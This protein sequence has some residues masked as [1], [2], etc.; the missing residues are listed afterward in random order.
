MVILIILII[1]L[2]LFTLF[3]QPSIQERFQDEQ[4]FRYRMGRGNDVNKRRTTL[5]YFKNKNMPEEAYLKLLRRKNPF[6][7]FAEPML[8][9]RC[10]EFIHDPS[11]RRYGI[12]QVISE[13]YAD[14]KMFVSDKITVD[15]IHYDTIE[16][17]LFTEIYKL[18]MR[19]N[20]AA[21]RID[22][23][24]G[25]SY[26]LITQY[27][28]VRDI[29]EDCRIIPRALR[30][31]ND[32]LPKPLDDTTSCPTQAKIIS[33]QV[34]RA[35]IYILLPLHTPKTIR[36]T[37]GKEYRI[38]GPNIYT[39]WDHILTNMRRLF[40]YNAEEKDGIPVLN[41]RSFDRKC[42][43]HCGTPTTNSYFYACGARNH[44]TENNTMSP[45]QSVV[46]GDSNKRQIQKHDFANLYL[47]NS[48]RM[49]M[50]LGLDPVKGIFAN[51]NTIR[52]QPISTDFDVSNESGLESC[53][54]TPIKH[55]LTTQTKL[56]GI[57]KDIPFKIK[58][59][60]D[61][62][63]YSNKKFR[64]VD[65]KDADLWYVDLIKENR[66]I[67]NV[68]TLKNNKKWYL[69]KNK[70]NDLILS[71]TIPKNIAF[72]RS[73]EK[74]LSLVELDNN[75]IKWDSH[76]KY[77][78]SNTVDRKIGLFTCNPSTQTIQYEPV[79]PKQTVCKIYQTPNDKQ[80]IM[81]LIKRTILYDETYM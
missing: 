11:T 71:P 5:L 72:K 43:L 24:I 78:I 34:I 3:I 19:S 4:H 66:D 65:S 58:I 59:E 17:T 46:L 62:L 23:F 53:V 70:S 79:L 1:V 6:Y 61:Y 20:A 27:P 22:Q 51:C 63:S 12:D 25:P 52:V 60:Y 73:A 36:T 67:V 39:T 7:E 54:Q 8:M 31:S 29:V 10:I 57:P 44:T 81:S 21:N 40:A 37:D 15:Y 32:Y 50:M 77:C 69:T 14:Q 30:Y 26:I 18:Y 35:E 28:F 16:T 42:N 33:D 55:T 45:Y 76:F 13:L 48:K 56:E 9:N 41:P 49:N 47:I 74:T 64:M 38:V 80:K 75:R 2:I 68:Y